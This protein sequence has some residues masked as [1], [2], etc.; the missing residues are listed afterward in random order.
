MKDYI[1]GIDIGSSKVCT[2]VG[3]I[4]DHQKLQVVGNVSKTCNGIKNSLIIDIDTVAEA[5]KCCI[6]ELEA[7]TDIP[8]HEAYIAIPGGV[9]E[10][11]DSRAAV[12][13]GSKKRLINEGDIDEVSNAAQNINIASDK[14]IIGII[15]Q[16]YIVDGGNAVKDPTNMMG[17]NL[18][19]DAK[20]AL[21]QGK[22]VSNI[23]KSVHLAGLKVKGIVLQPL[24]QASLLLDREAQEKCFA[25]VDIGAE[26][27]DLSIYKGGNIC[28]TGFIPFGGSNISKDLSLCLKL[29]FEE[30][31]R[32]KIIHHYADMLAICEDE[33]IKFTCVNNENI[34][35]SKSFLTDVIKARVE[36]ILQFILKEIN[37]SGLYDNIKEIIITGGGVSMF[38]NI[39]KYAEVIIGK[40]IRIGDFT[41]FEAVRPADVT[42]LGIVKTVFEE[43][44]LHNKD[45]NENLQ[46]QTEKVYKEDKAKGLFSKIKG[47]IGEIF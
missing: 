35:I 24:A 37:A 13:L 40:S 33:T 22:L 31:E 21:V 2:A 46:L 5:V 9:C 44:S 38:K 32:I 20:V 7:F 42:A 29:S 15:P 3:F 16:R 45:E 23:V 19:V 12:V 27:T 25:L 30:A 41:S 14:Q 43:L 6:K 4:D 11:V 17:T 36:E 28:Y 10:L 47:L 18:E 1:V 26:F 8:L 39:D 34:D